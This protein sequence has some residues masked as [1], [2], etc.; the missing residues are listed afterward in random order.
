MTTEPSSPLDD[1][2]TTVATSNTA[3]NTRRRQAILSFI[4]FIA[5]IFGAIY[6]FTEISQLNQRI[7]KLE[8]FAIAASSDITNISSELSSVGAM[9]RNADRYA[10]TH[11][12]SDANLKRDVNLIKMDCH[13]SASCDQ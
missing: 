3:S 2:E 11:G 13:P 4:L 9:A 8:Q 7:A 5:I 12:Y 6:L 1:N 10:H